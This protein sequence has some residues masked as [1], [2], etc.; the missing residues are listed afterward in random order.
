MVLDD[1]GTPRAYLN[2]CKHLP[3]PIDCGSRD[4]FDEDG[5]ELICVTHGAT[6]RLED[7]LC[8]FGPCK[9]EALEALDVARR[10][11]GYYVTDP[12]A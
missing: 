6:Y 1:A 4:F 8:T 10:E 5:K 11:D 12:L 2:R 7:G 3:I 9:G